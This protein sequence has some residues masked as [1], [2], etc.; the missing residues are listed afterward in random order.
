MYV[1]LRLIY[2][3][4]GRSFLQVIPR[5][6]PFG[7]GAGVY[8]FGRTAY[9]ACDAQ[10][11]GW[12]TVAYKFVDKSVV[13]VGRLYENLSLVLL[14]GSLFYLSY[15]SCSLV[16]IDRQVA[17]EGKTLSVE[18]TGHQRQQYR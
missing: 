8:L 17:Y 3:K 11:S 15:L 9:I 4:D 18:P 1:L 16:A 12:A 10:P 14:V 6:A 2:Q 7:N 5:F 13:T